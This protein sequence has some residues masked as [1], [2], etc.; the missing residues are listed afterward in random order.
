MADISKKIP[1]IQ[2]LSQAL[3]YIKENMAVF[4]WFSVVNFVFLLVFWHIDGGLSNKKSVLW[5]FSYYYYW[6]VFF[7]VYYNKKPYFITT[8]VF[9]SLI[10]STKMFFLVVAMSFLLAVLPYLPLLM[11]FDDEYLLFLENY[12]YQLQQAPV[13]ALNMMVLTAILMMFLPFILCRP[14]LG[15]IA[16]VQGL[17]GSIKKAW[18]KSAGNYWQFIA[19]MVLLNLPC[20]AVYEA[21]KH[22]N[23]NGYL[24]LVFYSVFFVYYNL[25]FAKIYDFFNNE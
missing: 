3:H 11:G 22:L 7:R 8:D 13:S 20:M 5:L 6:C 18:K 4:G 23:C 21:D 10:P 14:F 19:V 1:V 9:A 2:T 24:N 17:N 25:V 16:S 12:M 15:F